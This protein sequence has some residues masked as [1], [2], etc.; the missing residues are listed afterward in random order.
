VSKMKELGMSLDEMIEAGDGLV[1]SLKEAIHYVEII[2]G[3][4][5]DIKA[6]F[7]AG[8]EIKAAAIPA[9]NPEVKPA[10]PAAAE[11][12]KKTYTKE[13]VR[14][15]LSEKSGNGYR[16]QV[17]ELLKKYG[18]NNLSSINPDDYAAV[19]VEAEAFNG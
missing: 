3:A 9:T 18:A 6:M 19:V 13:E 4:A 2:L 17:K 11:P 8:P 7:S 14:K 12:E 10:A 16:E 15:V 5:K 1:T